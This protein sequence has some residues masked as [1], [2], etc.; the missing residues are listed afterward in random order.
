MHY[1]REFEEAK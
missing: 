1:A